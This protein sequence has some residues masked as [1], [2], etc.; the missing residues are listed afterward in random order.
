VFAAHA[1]QVTVEVAAREE[2]REYGLR[3][4]RRMQVRSLPRALNDRRQ[5]LGNDHEAQAQGREEC[6]AEG[7]HVHDAPIAIEAVQAGDRS[8]TVAELAVV[9]VLDNPRAGPAR[10]GEQFEPTGKAQWH[11]EWKL[12]RR[13]HVDDASRGRGTLQVVRVEALG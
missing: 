9:V 10:P 12:M 8:R 11:P 4:G 6:L 2:F 1:P 13:R 7:P 3:A 5:F